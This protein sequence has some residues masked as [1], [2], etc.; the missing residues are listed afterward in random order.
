MKSLFLQSREN[1][2]PESFSV[3]G[4]VAPARGFTL[5][6]L[7]VAMA[8]VGIMSAMVFSS[9][10]LAVNSY[11]KS[12]ERVVEEARRRVLQ[13]QIRRQIG[14]LFPL[15]PSFSVFS[16][17]I[18][19]SGRQNTPEQLL[20]SQVPLFYGTSD[21]MTFI[22]VAP[23][24]LHENP[25]LTVVRYGLAQD[26]FGRYYLG[27][28]EERYLGLGTFTEMVQSPQGRPYPLIKGMSQL[29]FEYYG[30]DTDSQSYGWWTHWS[31]EERQ[32]VPLAVRIQWDD[33]HLL[34][35]INANYFGG[36]IQTAIQNLLRR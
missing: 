18:T 2:G 20:Y 22:T 7:I 27:A 12:Q 5:L 35:L 30:Y 25:G 9:F 28:M 24:I 29:S 16:Q 26:E 8:I 19:S 36:R 21:A 4:A 23:L 32:A 11:E 6:E 10:R 31:G 17:R 3:A 14:S 15:R 34:V 13:D 1:R 33:R